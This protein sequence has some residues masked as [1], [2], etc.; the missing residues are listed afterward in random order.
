MN[1]SLVFAETV[2]C[3][4]HAELTASSIT[5]R[6]ESDRRSV[7]RDDSAAFELDKA[8]LYVMPA[9]R[10]GAASDEFA[11]DDIVLLDQD[12][13]PYRLLRRTRHHLPIVAGCLVATGWCAPFCLDDE[14]DARPPSEHPQRQR[15]RLT[16]AVTDSGI[17]SV[18]RQ[19]DRPDVVH[20]L[21]SRGMGDLPD[22]LEAWW[23]MT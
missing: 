16:V 11:L 15:V 23:K 1:A 21:P 8:R 20:S 3:L 12:E 2:D 6:L 22:V 5:H 4:V 9:A 10:E 18:M 7:E 14:V 19:G 17:A 13:N